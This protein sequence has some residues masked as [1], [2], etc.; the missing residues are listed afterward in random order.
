MFSIL[1]ALKVLKFN[2][3]LNNQIH[4]YESVY[5]SLSD[6]NFEDEKTISD[7]SF[8]YIVNVHI[9]FRVY[10]VVKTIQYLL[11]GYY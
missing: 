11:I 6:I 9:Y 3:T 7:V 5:K 8:F 10:Y 1:I 4:I 2:C